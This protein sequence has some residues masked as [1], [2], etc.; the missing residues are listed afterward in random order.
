M[1]TIPPI[2][3][4]DYFSAALDARASRGSEGGRKVSLVLDKFGEEV[5]LWPRPREVVLRDVE[6]RGL[7]DDEETSRGPSRGERTPGSEADD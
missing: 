5:C 6:G 2:A 4:Q 1:P 7:A 3:V